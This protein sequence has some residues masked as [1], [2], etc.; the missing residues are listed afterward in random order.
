MSAAE[1]VRTYRA[2]LDQMIAFHEAGARAARARR[3]KLVPA[4]RW[5]LYRWEHDYFI[6]H[7]VKGRLRLADAAIEPVRRELEFVAGRLARAPRAL[8][9]RDLQS[10]NIL[11]RRGRPWFIDFQGMRF[12]PAAY[13]LASLLCDPY[14]ELSEAVQL[15]LLDHYASRSAH[16]RAVARGFWPAAIQ[17]LGQAL[18]AYARLGSQADTAAFARHIPAALRMLARACAHVPEAAALRRLTARADS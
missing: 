15:E 2:V 8:V 17:R 3:L 14:V 4:F 13:D 12:G 18:G 1:V 10:S 11:L 5:T 9:H 6:D 16:P 7:F